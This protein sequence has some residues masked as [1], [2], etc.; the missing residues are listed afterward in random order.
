MFFTDKIKSVHSEFKNQLRAPVFLFVYFSR[1]VFLLSCFLKAE[2]AVFSFTAFLLTYLI[3]FCHLISKEG[4][5]LRKLSHKI[6]PLICFSSLVSCFVGKVLGVLDKIPDYDIFMS[7]V[8]GVIGTIFGCFVT[9]ALRDIKHKRD[10]A[11]VSSSSLFI[12]GTVVFFREM[13]EFFSD[14]LFGTN[15]VHAEQISDNHWFFRIFSLGS[16]IPQQRPLFDTDEDMLISLLVSAFTTIFIYAYL[17]TKNKS[18]FIKE[19]K[20]ASV[21]LKEKISDKIYGEI[22]KIKED[23]NV[24]DM[25]TWWLTR[26]VMVYAFIMIEDPAEQ[27]LIGANLL[28]TFAISF[29]HLIF[30]DKSLFAKIN[31]RLQ[32]WICLLVF[33]GSYMGNFIFVY[34]H[35]PRFDLFLHFISGPITVAGGYYTAKTFIKPHTRHNIFL[36]CVYSFCISCFVMPFWEVFEFLGDFLFGS[37]NQGFYWGPTDDS[38]FFKVFGHGVGNTKLYYLFDTVYDVL[39]A[40]VTTVVSVLWLYISLLR[41]LKAL[42]TDREREKIAVN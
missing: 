24:Y 34:N 30:P 5:F 13:L 36:I 21:P 14:Y 11:F 17:R 27:V 23:T 31:Y 18:L 38:F 37:A 7:V 40:F 15:Y 8:T 29:L 25:L 9:L 10:C 33:T 22:Q 12:S 35:L 28:A 26:A 16:N 39:L 42:K 4:A 41:K 2:T 20:S 6:T 32:S 19:K 3:S 1:T